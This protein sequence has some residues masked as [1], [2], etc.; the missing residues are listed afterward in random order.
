[1]KI[2]K[3]KVANGCLF[4]QLKEGDVFVNGIGLVHVKVKGENV[5]ALSIDNSNLYQ[6]F[7]GSTLVYPVLKMKV[8][9]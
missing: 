8:V 6:N 2:K 7:D 1:M 9:Y 4:A 3:K 5:N